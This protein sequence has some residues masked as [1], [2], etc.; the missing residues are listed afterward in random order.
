MLARSLFLHLLHL[1][2][3]FVLFFLYLVSSIYILSFSDLTCE[4]LLGMLLFASSSLEF[5]GVF[6]QLISR[7][8]GN[9][10]SRE[11]DGKKTFSLFDQF[12]GRPKVYVLQK[13]RYLAKLLSETK[14]LYGVI[15][16][17]FA[18]FMKTMF[19]P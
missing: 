12:F 1:H 18:S 6:S 17:V 10:D 13:S 7:K 16:T 3:F 2:L 15:E 5:K 8:R 19:F 14:R 11:F 9:I 4:I